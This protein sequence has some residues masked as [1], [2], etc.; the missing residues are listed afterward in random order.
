MPKPIDYWPTPE[1]AVRGLIPHLDPKL[2][3][4]EPCA[5][6]GDLMKH[7]QHLDWVQAFDASPHA[8]AITPPGLPR[9]E[10]GD[11]R[12]DPI[13]ADAVLTDPPFD[14]D[15]LLPMMRHWQAQGVTQWLLLPA[16]RIINLYFAPFAGDVTQLVPIRRLK[17]IDGSRHQGT[18]DFVWV[19]LEPG[20]SSGFLAARPAA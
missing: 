16:T 6:R 5:G 13:S 9:I 15:H 17:W 3:Y 11:A 12:R 8:C 14:T 19:K 4:A 20:A 7:L 1:K 2:T 10:V 18:K